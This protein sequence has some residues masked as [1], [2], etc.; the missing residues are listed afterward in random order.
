MLA[1]FMDDFNLI[2]TIIAGDASNS[3]ASEQT[4]NRKAD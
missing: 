1:S 3:D 2:L 4:M